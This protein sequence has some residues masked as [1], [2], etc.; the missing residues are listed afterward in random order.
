VDALQRRERSVAAQVDDHAL[1]LEPGGTLV[2]AEVDHGLDAPADP[3]GRDLA[4]ET[5]PRGRPGRSPG[6]PGLEGFE[7]VGVGT[8]F[9]RQPTLVAVH[10]RE[11]PLPQLALDPLLDE[12]TIGVHAA[13]L[14]F[15]WVRPAWRCV[16][17]PVVVGRPVS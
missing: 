5:E 2:E 13:T 8:G 3:L 15:R 6:R 16:G 7:M 1:A 14:L 10:E 17:R 9:D 12:V 4:G 11:H